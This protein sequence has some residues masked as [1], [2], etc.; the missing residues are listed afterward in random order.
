M[1]LSELLNTKLAFP[2]NREIKREKERTEKEETFSFFIIIS[3]DKMMKEFSEF[4]I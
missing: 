2:K 3:N 4:I 1:Q